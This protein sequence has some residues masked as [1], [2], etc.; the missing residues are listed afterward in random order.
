[1]KLARVLFLLCLPLAVAC[2]GKPTE[3]GAAGGSKPSREGGG[4]LAFAADVMPVEAKKVTYTVNAPGTIEAFERVQVTARV[5]GVVDRVA[6]TEGQEVKKGDVLVVIDSERYQLAVNGAKAA[7]A[8]TEAAVRDMEAMVARR[9]GAS[10]MNPG[11]IPGEE[12]ESYKSKVLTAKADRDIAFQALRTAQLNL[13][14]SSV[15]AP[16][17]GAIQTRTVET[18]Q[19]VQAGYVMATLLQSEPLLLRFQ[20]EPLEAPRLKVGTTATFTMRETLRKFSAK[21]TLI[22]AAADPT[23]HMV[24]VTGEVVDDGHKYWL[25]PGSFCDVSVDIGAQREAVTIP[26]LAARATDHGY[27]A[28]V[29]ENGVAKERVLSLGMSTQ[30]GWVEVRSGLAA[31]D[32]LV[33]RGA[34]ALNDGAKVKPTT[35]TPEA[36]LTATAPSAKPTASS[37]PPPADLA[38]GEPASSPPPTPTGSASAGVRP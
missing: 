28:Y 38:S 23:T 30:D 22:A 16:M 19:Y 12:L 25:R 8:K 32:V 10:G 3:G 26:R 31:G 4:G 15:R 29:V 11:L 6:F 5:A 24:P 27:V 2:K 37:A 18:G 9:E 36:L 34:E 14:D 20:V 1:M 35:I 7:L 21:I 13:R 17:A 33:V